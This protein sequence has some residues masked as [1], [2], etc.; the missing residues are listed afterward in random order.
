MRR[1]PAVER[2]ICDITDRDIRV[3]II[4]TVIQKDPI[5]YS[6]VVDDGTGAV[7]V[8]ADTL[9]EVATVIRVIGR[10]QFRGEPVIEAEVVQDFTGFDLELY[11]R[12]KEMES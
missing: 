5:A 1:A 4:G 6:M 3:S 8:L 2:D 7:T 10:P 12:V 11:R 9:Y